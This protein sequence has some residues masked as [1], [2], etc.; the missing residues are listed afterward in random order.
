M[1][2]N[3]NVSLSDEDREKIRNI[4]NRRNLKSVANNF[5]RQFSKIKNNINFKSEDGNSIF[6]NFQF[7]LS[8]FFDYLMTHIPDFAIKYSIVLIL[9]VVYFCIGA[10]MLYICKIA[11][12]NFLPVFGDC[13]PYSSSELNMSL[14]DYVTNIF[15]SNF[16]GSDISVNLNFNYAENKNNIILDAIRNYCESANAN[17]ILVYILSIASEIIKYNYNVINTLFYNVG[18]LPDIIVI[19]LS[20][21]ILFIL[22]IFLI[23]TNNIYTVFLWFYKMKW[24]FKK[25]EN[26]GGG[27]NVKAK[28]EDISLFK[29]PIGFY[30]GLIFSAIAS[31]LSIV[32]VISLVFVPLFNLPTLSI[33]YTMISCLGFQSS[34]KGKTLNV[35]NIM[36]NVLKYYKSPF[37]LATCLFTVFRSTISEKILKLLFNFNKIKNNTIINVGSSVK[38]FDTKLNKMDVLKVNSYAQRNSNIMNKQ[39]DMLYKQRQNEANVASEINKFKSPDVLND[40][41]NINIPFSILILC[42]IY[43]IISSVGYFKITDYELFSPVVEEIKNEVVCNGGTTS[44]PNDR[45]SIYKAYMFGR[46]MFDNYKKMMEIRKENM[47]KKTGTAKLTKS[48]IPGLNATTTVKNENNATDTDTNVKPNTDTNAKPNTDTNAKPKRDVKSSSNS[49][50]T[51]IKK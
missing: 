31:M 1:N 18:K 37:F 23:T 45:T 3:S 46:S 49:K 7:F 47:A 28:W 48:I 42:I 22:L 4:Q 32:V 10:S 15:T 25:N 5:S 39:L 12:T 51:K 40:A 26:C 30:F 33:A 44:N 13:F 6:Q 38:D 16:N 8:E 21:L 50:K 34:A 35:V 24:F 27:K 17:K 14:K 20:P 29:D 11:K 41:Y 19:L 9:S 43:G 36:W 2:D